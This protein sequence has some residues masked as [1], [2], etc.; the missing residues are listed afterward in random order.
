[1]VGEQHISTD[2]DTLDTNA[3]ASFPPRSSLLRLPEELRIEVLKHIDVKSLI[4]CRLVRPNLL[5]LG[6]GGS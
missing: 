5:L 3:M 6:K 2:A 4:R 1:M